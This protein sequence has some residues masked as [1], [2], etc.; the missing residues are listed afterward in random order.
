MGW[1]EGWNAG[2]D[3]AYRMALEKGKLDE[4]DYAHF[5]DRER[6]KYWNNYVNAG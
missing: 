3:Y 2:F 4:S 1:D 6:E 5:K